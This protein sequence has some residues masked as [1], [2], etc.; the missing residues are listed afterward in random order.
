MT[1]AQILAFNLALLV[2]IASP[3]P[4]L[5]MALRTTL[6]GGRRAGRCRW[7]RVYC[8]WR[9]NLPDEADNHVVELA[10][11]GG[12]EAIITHDSRDFAGAELRFPALRVLTP[13]ALIAED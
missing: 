7:V 11:A 10:V 4:A 3:G 6:S 5:L 12:A 13:G 1:L 8:L 2:A 9:P